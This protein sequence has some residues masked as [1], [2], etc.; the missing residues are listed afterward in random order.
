MAMDHENGE[1][2]PEDSAAK[3]EGS[4]PLPAP[5]G[6]PKG[7]AA[8][9]RKQLAR[10]Q[11]KSAARKLAEAYNDLPSRKLARDIAFGLRPD[12]TSAAATA[13]MMAESQIFKPDPGITAALATLKPLTIDRGL[14][15]MVASINRPVIDPTVMNALQG[16]Q[17]LKIDPSLAQA[18]REAHK[19]LEDAM[20]PLGGVAKALKAFEE[21][22]RAV[23]Q[24]LVASLGG[25]VGEVAKAS[26]WASTIGMF[27]SSDLNKLIG[28]DLVTTVKSMR[29]AISRTFTDVARRD[30]EHMSAILGLTSP[31]SDQLAATQLKMSVLAGVGETV[32]PFSNIQVEA[33][34][35]L[36]GDWRTRPDL[37]ENFWRDSRVRKR[38]YR[39]AE[40]DDG[41]VAAAPGVA[42]EVMIESGLTAGFRSEHNAVAV[43]TLGDVS[44]TVR[45]SGTRKD[46][47]S[48]L[49]R[50]ELELRDYVSRKLEERFG[51]D[52][53]KARASNLMG[54]AK[55]NRTAA[56]KRGEE[57][58]PLINFIDLGELAG[59]ILSNRNWDEVFGDIFIN[60]TEFDHD[61]Q[62]LVATRRPT[63][64]VRAVD[65]VRLVEL[66]CVMQRLSEQMANDGAWK[67]AAESDR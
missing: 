40:V 22:Q 32:S 1:E 29:E 66:I 39:E 30:Q 6:S 65:G 52:W 59:L 51:P 43:V 2:R 10:E 11:G 56:M 31:V 17:P 34:H 15:D 42:L 50:F 16:I 19:A 12:I 21:Q 4:D 45:S 61:M 33:Y 67:E 46:A 47:Y 5:E 20:R 23:Q 3:S 28:G 14:A 8:S 53:F 38:M 35:S 49:D 57:F 64:H 37:P 36:F 41:L 13:K 18:V 54:K 27:S 63:M 60:K 25:P 55:E 48:V 26:Q 7:I 24:S 44:M 58:A 62:K 9:S